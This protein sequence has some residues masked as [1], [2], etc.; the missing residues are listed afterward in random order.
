[1]PCSVKGPFP[2][3][4]QPEWCM[5][6]VLGNPI[7]HRTDICRV[8]YRLIHA[9]HRVICIRSR[10]LPDERGE[11]KQRR[12]EDGQNADNSLPLH[13]KEGGWKKKIMALMQSL[14]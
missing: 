2:S 8:R 1:V 4:A 7:D 6:R 13:S 10:N 9:Q 3:S 14:L 11:E 5:P 12:K